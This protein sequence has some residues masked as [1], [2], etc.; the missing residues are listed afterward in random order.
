MD[1]DEMRAFQYAEENPGY[2]REL[3]PIAP[4][5][6]DILDPDWRDAW[7]AAQEH[8]DAENAIIR[9]SNERTEVAR[10]RGILSAH[11]IDPDQD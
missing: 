11:G 4:T 5:T 6:E 7:M 2:Q 3:T 8:T 1:Y 10:L 9:A